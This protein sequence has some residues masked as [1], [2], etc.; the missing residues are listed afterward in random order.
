MIQFANVSFR[1]PDK[2]IITRCS[3]QLSRQ[4]RT[5]LIGINGSGKTTVIRLLAGRLTPDEG[6][7]V[8][9]KDV[10]IGLLPQTL[11]LSTGRTLASEMELPFEHLKVMERELAEM[12]RVMSVEPGHRLSEKY[13]RFLELYQRRGGYEFHARIRE[14]L[15]GLGFADPEMDRPLNSFSGGERSR[16]QLAR[17][18]LEDP[19]LVLLDEP[20]NHLDVDSIE[21]L[22]RYLNRF[23]G[24]VLV[25]SH[26][27]FFL[28]RVVTEILDLNRMQIDSYRG[29]YTVYL[30]QRDE[31][32]RQR[33][34]WYRH[35]QSRIEKMED[36]VR[37]NIAGQKT[38]MAQSRLN[39]LARMERLEKPAG[40]ARA[41]RLHFDGHPQSGRVVLQL[42]NVAKQFDDILLFAGIS[43]KVHRGEIIGMLGPNGSGKTTLL[44]II[45]G[46]L[47]P[48]EGE[49]RFGHQVKTAYFDQHLEDL[50][51]ENTVLDE[52][53]QLRPNETQF[54]MRSHLGRFLF[55]GDDVFQP[56]GSLSGGEKARVALAKLLLKNANLLI[57]DEPTNHLDMD[58]KEVLEGSLLEFPGTVLIVTHDRYLLDKL[59]DRIWALERGTVRDYL[60]N[61]SRYRELKTVETGQNRIGSPEEISKTPSKPSR[62]DI[63][64]ARAVIREKTGKSSRHFEKEIERLES[65]LAKIQEETKNPALATDWAALDNLVTQARNIQKEL[66][67]AMTGWE[68][69]LEEEKKI[70]DLL[71]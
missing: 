29:N 8:V 20:T 33:E 13:D 28:D 62:R 3:F 32:L 18:L 68:T 48:D 60:G 58:S 41:M 23:K 64:K 61:Y 57:M 22:E 50:N 16:I 46:R 4:C 42:E 2:Q 11:E 38:K 9:P 14:V 53:W 56:V 54:A 7:I 30:R 12:N 71:S 67:R 51:P 39:T 70:E 17:L 59:S 35:Q 26:D 34:K 10:K 36:F 40:T 49:I 66:N 15:S 25:I 37:R 65:E 24:G 21:W 55:S 63:R 43:L 52:V 27:R 19:D 6:H 69:A 1:F 44:K 31:I 5:G 47:K 45:S